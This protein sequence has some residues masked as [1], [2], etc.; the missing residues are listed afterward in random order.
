[1]AGLLVLH[2]ENLFLRTQELLRLT[3]AVE[4]PLH[5]QRVLLIH[6]GHGIDL[7]VA[8]ETANALGDVNAVVEIYKIREIVHARPLDG[9]PAVEAP[10]DRLQHGFIGPDLRVAVHTGLGGRNAGKTRFFNRGVAIAA[11]ET[12]SRGVML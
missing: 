7:P 2:V 3:M 1:M 9:L 12:Q 5:L 10:A 6:E 11:V 4:A 8:A